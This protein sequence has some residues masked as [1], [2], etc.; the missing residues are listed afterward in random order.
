MLRS[1]PDYRINNAAI[2]DA[3]HFLFATGNEAQIKIMGKAVP[4]TLA[5]EGN[6]LG[7]AISPDG[8]W[9]AAGGLYKATNPLGAVHEPIVC[10]FDLASD[11]PEP[12]RQQIADGITQ[13]IIWSLR[14]LSDGTLMGVTGGGTGG[15]LLF[16]KPDADKD[17]HRFQLPSLARDMDLH[18]DGVQV[19]TAHHDRH[20]RLIKL[21][22]KG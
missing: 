8:K 2:L 11:K 7:A 3:G 10:L 15:L 1:G 21:A 6:V 17:F 19:I 18:P 9:L 4:S 13:G 12:V 14:W 22:A 20:V 16:W 5:V